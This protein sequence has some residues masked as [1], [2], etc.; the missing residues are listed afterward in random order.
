[1]FRQMRLKP[2]KA[3]TVT[4]P[5]A[6][7]LP[8]ALTGK[9]QL[10][11]DAW[12]GIPLHYGWTADEQATLEQGRAFSYLGGIG[13]V[14]VSGP[15]RL[16][17]L[18]TLSSQ[19]LTDLVPGLS[20]E[21]LL[22][23]AQGRVSFQF[24]A[25]DDGETTW[26]LTEAAYAADLTSF[27]QSMQFMLRVEIKDVSDQYIAIATVNQGEQSAEQVKAWLDRQGGRVWADPWP[28]VV[29]GGAR[30]FSGA[31][32]GDGARFRVDVCP[33]AR[34][35][36]FVEFLLALGLEP[37]GI[38]AFQACRV[39]AW[40]PLRGSEVDDRTLPAEL[41]WLRTAVHL[42][43]GCYCGQESVARIVNL[44]KPP[45]RLV[46]LQLDGSAESLP[47]PGSVV[48]AGGRQVGVVTS[49]ARHWEMGPIALALVK[50][51]LDPSEPLLVAGVDAAQEVVVP[52][53]GRSDRA[54][55]QRPG[56]GL[57][58]LPTDHRDIRTRGPGAGG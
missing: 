37:A 24:G 6:A 40:R 13:V 30:Y 57:K 38:L 8:G 42:D 17:W 21:G 43:K 31:H 47:P 29:D 49:S 18:T 19:V 15:D 1:M 12:K 16:S 3:A 26:L 51:N 14:T 4:N 23:D 35:D 53:E 48:E 32:P 11:E 45:R 34:T 5:R 10:G 50:R 52:V 39:A 9:A 25:L 55:S 2:A 54:P 58:R 7:A 41:D 33:V 46:F 20:K 28:G 44:G 22:L 27:L 36:E 56:A